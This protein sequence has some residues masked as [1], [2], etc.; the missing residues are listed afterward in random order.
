MTDEKKSVE[1]EKED[2]QQN[3]VDQ[4][5]FAN[6]SLHIPAIVTEL[7]AIRTRQES[8]REW[9][10][11]QKGTDS[12]KRFVIPLVLS[13]VIGVILGRVSS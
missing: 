9:V 2:V 5:R 12:Y 8:I 13:I 1:Q 3:K 10:D 4:P 7:S 6:G 11:Q